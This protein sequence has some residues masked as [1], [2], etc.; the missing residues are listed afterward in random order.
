[1]KKVKIVPESEI[2]ETS[3][4][5]LGELYN[6]FAE[7][8]G[9][10]PIKK[11]KDKTTGIKR[12]TEIQE[13]Y[14]SAALSNPLPTIKTDIAPEKQ[15]F[16]AYG[17]TILPVLKP[18]IKAEALEVLP[19][20]LNGASLEVGRHKKQKPATE[21]R[22][23]PSKL[24]NNVMLGAVKNRQPKNPNTANA[25]MW[26]YAASKGAVNC[27]GMIEH[28]IKEYSKKYKGVKT[29]DEAF[30][31]GYVCGAVRSQILEILE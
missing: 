5:S 24:G 25:I 7:A 2:K 13:E 21:T 23:A 12:V 1:M 27:K 28:F 19:E 10:K 16:V 31:R 9:K 18:E 15:D 6:R 14:K 8:M 26:S 30:A 11:F 4:K 29:V 22:G 17:K 20:Q 3:F